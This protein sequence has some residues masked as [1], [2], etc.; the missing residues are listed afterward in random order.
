MHFHS[1]KKGKIVDMNLD[2]QW[3]SELLLLLLFNR[4]PVEHL[5]QAFPFL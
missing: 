4:L 5:V 1:F 3:L 2:N